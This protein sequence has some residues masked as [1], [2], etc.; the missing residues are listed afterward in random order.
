[1]IELKSRI[2]TKGSTQHNITNNG[3]GNDTT[4]TTLF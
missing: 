2:H 1:M 4:N 3:T